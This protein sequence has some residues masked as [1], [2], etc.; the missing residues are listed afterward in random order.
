MYGVIEYNNS[1]ASPMNVTVLH[2]YED[3]N[4]AF[5][6]AK[7]Y[8]KK[9]AKEYNKQC[10]AHEQVVEYV[11]NNQIAFIQSGPKYTIKGGTE[12]LVYTVIYLPDVEDLIRLDNSESEESE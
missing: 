11:E 6:I 12:H 8:A 3:R 10:G 1:R 5:K 9:Y 7:R 4:V 2:I